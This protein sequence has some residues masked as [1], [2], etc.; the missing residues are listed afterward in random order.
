M[1]QYENIRTGNRIHTECQITGEDWRE[2]KPASQLKQEAA[3]T[4][5]EPQKAKSSSTG[6]KKKLPAK[7]AKTKV[8][9]RAVKK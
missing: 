4:G 6:T 9:A 3:S 8:S 1:M 2:I 5:K 7:T